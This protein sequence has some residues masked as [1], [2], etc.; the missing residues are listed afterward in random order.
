M[1]RGAFALLACV[2]L[3]DKKL[4]NEEFREGLELIVIGVRDE[5]NFVKKGVVWALRGIGS[6]NAEMRQEAL[7]VAE[8]L[9]EASSSA[10]RWVG[11][12]ALKELSGKVA[13]KRAE[14]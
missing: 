1:K 13:R 12:T 3:H 14:K 9:M 10:A 8:R 5:R 2:A 11:K 7:M 4:G 6:R